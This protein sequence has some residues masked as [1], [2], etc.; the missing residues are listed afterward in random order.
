MPGR[1]LA[2]DVRHERR[3]DGVDLNLH[4]LVARTSGWNAHLQVIARYRKR[5]VIERQR[6]MRGAALREHETSRQFG[7]NGPQSRAA[8]FH[9]E[10]VWTIA[11]RRRF[12]AGPI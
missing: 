3:D 11:K 9:L 8:F 12:R 2:G 1:A 4:P 7:T 5:S 6:T 10:A